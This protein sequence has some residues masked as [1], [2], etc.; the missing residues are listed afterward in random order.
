MSAR[1]DIVLLVT[2]FGP[3][4]GAPFNPSAA[5]VGR[6]D[7][8]FARRLA[9]LGVRLETRILDVLHATIAPAL[10]ALESELAPDAVLHFGLAGRRRVVTVEQR[11]HNR[12][13]LFSVDAARRL[14]EGLV[15]ERGG[16]ATRRASAPLAPLIAALDR[17]APTRASIDAGAYV[18]NRTLWFSLAPAARRRPT[19]FIHIPRPRRT[20]ARKGSDVRPT[21]ADLD[22]MAEAACLVMARAARLTRR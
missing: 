11:A 12:N 14:P 9:R 3:F 7:G 13:R 10:A 1:R 18:C 15:L 8:A 21:R 4:P 17:L 22:R 5:I 2:G 20:A 6:L 19:V 16:P